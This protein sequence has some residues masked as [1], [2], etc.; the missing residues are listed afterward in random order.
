MKN[1]EE[2]IPI[3]FGGL[4][5]MEVNLVNVVSTTVSII[6]TVIVKTVV[7]TSTSKYL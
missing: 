5:L 3:K 1:F 4:N 2:Q 6:T 7:S